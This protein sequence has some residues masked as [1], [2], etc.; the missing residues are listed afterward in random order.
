MCHLCGSTKCG[1]NSCSCKCGSK[2]CD[3][4]KKISGAAFQ[5]NFVKYNAIFQNELGNT[6]FPPDTIM[7]IGPTVAIAMVNTLIGYYQRPSMNRVNLETMNTFFPFGSTSGGGDVQVVYDEFSQR[8]FALAWVNIRVDAIVTVT[9][10]G[11]IAGTYDARKSTFGPQ[12]FQVPAVGS[13]SIVPTIPITAEIGGV[14]TITNAAAIAG[15]IALIQRGGTAP[16]SAFTAK[17]KAAQNAGAIGV[18]LFDNVVGPLTNATGVDPTITIPSVRITLADGNLLLANMPVMG[19]ISSLSTII[20]RNYMNI[21]VSKTSAPLSTNDWYK[22]QFTT[23][24]WSTGDFFAD[25]VKIAVDQERLYLATQDISVVN[26]LAVF[27]AATVSVLN[28]NDLVTNTAPQFINETSSTFVSQ[29]SYPDLWIPQPARIVYSCYKD[30]LPQFFVTLANY[31]AAA[32]NSRITNAATGL[33][34]FVGPSMTSFV[35]VPFPTT[36]LIDSGATAI[37]P[38][39]STGASSFP[40]EINQHWTMTAVIWGTSIFTAHGILSGTKSIIRWYEL[41]VSRAASYGVITIKQW[42]DIDTCQPDESCIIPAMNVDKCGNMGIVFTISGPNTLPT[43][44]YTG[45][46][47]N[48]PLGTVRKPYQIIKV[49]P[50]PYNGGIQTRNYT[51]GPVT[52][53]RW[54]DYKGLVIDPNDHKTFFAFGENS[55]DGQPPAIPTNVDAQGRAL[56]WTTTMSSFNIKKSCKNDTYPAGRCENVQL[57]SAQPISQ[58][59][60]KTQDIVVLE[61]EL[62]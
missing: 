60:D 22:Y 6:S 62:E 15:N 59:A 7:A 13:V 9:S 38:L 58:L 49:S 19:S 10:P 56:R 54:E 11:N 14:S 29:N 12:T 30:Y 1:H 18:I 35:D 48:D 53:N 45:R 8:F 40:L 5:T 17:V 24:Y 20:I 26:D 50:F 21:A 4:C 32:R 39:S 27:L 23:N 16:G 33:R 37:Q 43:F 61:D 28:K 57:E 44:A 47:K 25:Y 55:T 42:G 51:T 2:C 36:T 31:G 52:Q 41:D 3:P 34:V 46:L